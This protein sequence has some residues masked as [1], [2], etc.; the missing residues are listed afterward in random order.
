MGHLLFE[1]DV[2]DPRKHQAGQVSA[3]TFDPAERRG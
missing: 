2:I 3:G 1:K